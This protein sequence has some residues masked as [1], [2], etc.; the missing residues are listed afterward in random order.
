[1]LLIHERCPGNA[2]RLR[3]FPLAELL[4]E[5]SFEGRG[6]DAHQEERSAD[7]GEKNRERARLLLSGV[8]AVPCRVSAQA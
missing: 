7:H 3:S 6:H 4:D 8:A 1:V 2:E 5:P